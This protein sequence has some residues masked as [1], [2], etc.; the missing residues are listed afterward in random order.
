MQ[1]LW[2]NT[3]NRLHLSDAG[4]FLITNNFSD[5]DGPID[6]LS[7]TKFHFH[8]FLVQNMTRMALVESFLPCE[9][10]PAKPPQSAQSSTFPQRMINL[11]TLHGFSSLKFQTPAWIFPQ[12]TRPGLHGNSPLSGTDFDLSLLPVA[13]ISVLGR[14]RFISLTDY[15]AWWR[16]DPQ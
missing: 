14:K 5:L 12:T 3:P 4:F 7:K 1:W 2:G 16:K 15:S 10:C 8:I 6:F 11:R 9:L 13:M